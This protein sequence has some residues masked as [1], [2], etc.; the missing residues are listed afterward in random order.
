M[1][2][3]PVCHLSSGRCVSY[4][5]RL[6]LDNPD[7]DRLTQ[8]DAVESLAY[9]SKKIGAWIPP[10]RW[11]FAKRNHICEICGESITFSDSLDS[12]C[13][14]CN[15]VV[16]VSCLTQTQRNQTFR[17][18]WI[19]D[20]C[21]DDIKDS[22]QHFVVLKSKRNYEVNQSTNPNNICAG[23]RH[24]RS[25]YNFKNLEKVSPGKVLQIH[26]AEHPQTPG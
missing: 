19:C 9:H 7:R 6:G 15:V 14:L 18:G 3:S 4:V 1:A 11:D 17:N 10:E 25:N 8:L 24:S 2:L 22:K 23:S 21:A 13:T 12:K 16:H 26:S 20:D 5:M